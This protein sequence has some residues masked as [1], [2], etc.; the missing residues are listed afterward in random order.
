MANTDQIRNSKTQLQK[1]LRSSSPSRTGTMLPPPRP[2]LNT[3]LRPP[4][5]AASTL[6]GPLLR[7][8]T[9]STLAPIQVQGKPQPSRQV[10]LEPGRSPLDWAALTSQPNHK[11]RGGKSSTDTHSCNAVDVEGT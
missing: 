10:A 9:S 6:R 8:L 11:L 3:P 7:G 2:S 1:R 5:S 4:L